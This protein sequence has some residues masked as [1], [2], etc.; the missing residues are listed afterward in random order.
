MNIPDIERRPLGSPDQFVDEFKCPRCGSKVTTD[1]QNYFCKNEACGWQTHVRD[2]KPTWLQK[3]WA[4]INGHKS[5]LCFIGM[6]AGG[7]LT[8]IPYTA[9]FGK[10]LFCVSFGGESV[11]LIHREGKVSKYGK[12]GEFNFKNLLEAL[13]DLIKAI[14]RIFTYFKR[15]KESC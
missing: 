1:G 14:V 10:A 15:R 4:K 7:V 9:L 11:S 5:T 6:L 2:S 12:P 13:G 8:L 3:V